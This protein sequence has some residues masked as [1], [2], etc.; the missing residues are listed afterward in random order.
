MPDQRPLIGI[1]GLG[2]LGSAVAERCGHHGLPVTLRASRGTGWRVDTVP[3]V[4]IDASAPAAHER[5]VEYCGEH[6]VALVECVSNLSSAQWSRIAELATH[7]PIVRATNLTIGN[8]VQSLLVRY[9][10]SLASFHYPASV[11][12]RHPATKAHRPSATAVELARTWTEQTNTEPTEISSQ[13]CG[14]P[15]SEH[16]FM[17]T[18]SAETLTLRHS[19]TSFAAAADGAIAAA[20]SLPG[21]EAGLVGMHAVYDDLLASDTGVGT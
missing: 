8:Y 10:G 1:V 21:R 20:R 16:E 11:W 19:V 4:L 2:R 9:V 3:D 18:L 14:L 5:V 6:G 15:V 17:W 13:R 12:E 7:V